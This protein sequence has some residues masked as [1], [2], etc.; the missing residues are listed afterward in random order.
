MLELLGIVK[1]QR[2]TGAMAWAVCDGSTIQKALCSKTFQVVGLLTLRPHREIVCVV[3]PRV[4]PWWAFEWLGA[5]YASG[6]FRGR[7]EG[8]WAL[9]DIQAPSPSE[10]REFIGESTHALA[11]RRSS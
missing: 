6:D 7:L 5:P 9:S 1:D 4:S 3:N 11:P 2:D 8:C 10:C